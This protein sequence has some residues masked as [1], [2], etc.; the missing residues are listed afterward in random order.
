MSSSCPCDGCRRQRFGGALLS[1]EWASTQIVPHMQAA[2]ETTPNRILNHGR[3]SRS[4]I[5]GQHIAD[6]PL[7]HLP[8]GI[9]VDRH[10]HDDQCLYR[11]S[12][13][14][15]SPGDFLKNHPPY[16]SARPSA[17]AVKARPTFL[18]AAPYCEGGRR[19]GYWKKN[20][21]GCPRTW[22]K[23]DVARRLNI[24]ASLRQ[25][26]LPN[27]IAAGTEVVAKG[28]PLMAT[29]RCLAA[30]NRG[31]GWPISGIFGPKRR[32]PSPSAVSISRTRPR[33][34][35]T[36]DIISLNCP[37][38]L[39][40][41]PWEMTRVPKRITTP[42][43]RAF[44][45]ANY[46]LPSALIRITPDLTRRSHGLDDLIF[47]RRFRKIP[48]NYYVPGPTRAEFLGH[49]TSAAERSRNGV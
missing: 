42:T 18:G 34:A 29:Q 16:N 32:R 38:A 21:A 45:Y 33:S 46:T 22:G 2:Q 35:R 8:P 20:T 4:H 39:H 37:L 15:L 23:S 6:R 19:T 24:H 7:H 5:Y 25:M 9:G 12:F 36:R 44:G 1:D 43:D 27:L 49:A 17:T 30:T 10:A 28:K 11:Q 40:Q 26:P 3:P 31:G 47:P 13:L 41:N 48:Y 14:S